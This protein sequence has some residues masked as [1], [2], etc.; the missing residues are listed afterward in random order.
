MKPTPHIFMLDDE[1]RLLHS[2]QVN[3]EDSYNFHGFETPTEF[4][5]AVLSHK[6]PAI[7]VIDHHL[8]QGQATDG[9]HVTERI[10]KEHTFG[11]ILPII[12]YSAGFDARQFVKGGVEHF[13][14]SPNVLLNKAS[15]GDTGDL[16]SVI[17]AARDMLDQVLSLSSDQSLQ[18]ALNRPGAGVD[19][20]LFAGEDEAG[21]S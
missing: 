10:R 15:N 12:Y 14:F 7:L 20:D 4:I 8:G 3:V 16:E 19:F 9:L 2:I 5:D 11:L 6:A 18:Q 17:D 13:M 1:A 21:R